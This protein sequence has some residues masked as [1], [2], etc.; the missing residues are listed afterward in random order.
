MFDPLYVVFE[1]EIPVDLTRR[2]EGDVEIDLR[3]VGRDELLESFGEALG[4]FTHKRK[5]DKAC[6]FWDGRSWLAFDGHINVF[7]NF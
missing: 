3:I 1:R 6:S 7:I 5:D 2:L 4:F